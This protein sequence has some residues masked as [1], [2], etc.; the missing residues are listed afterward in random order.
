MIIMIGEQTIELS[1]TW[2]ALSRISEPLTSQDLIV[3]HPNGF[4]RH[5]SVM[6]SLVANLL[7]QM[8]DGLTK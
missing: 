3:G 7:W 2:R 6:V 1:P 4:K 5:K 8:N